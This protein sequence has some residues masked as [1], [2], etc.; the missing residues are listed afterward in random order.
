MDFEPGY[1]RIYLQ[2]TMENL[3]TISTKGISAK[4]KIDELLY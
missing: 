4:E 3:F 2:G 1:V